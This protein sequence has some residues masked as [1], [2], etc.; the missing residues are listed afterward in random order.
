[1]YNIFWCEMKNTFFIFS[2]LLLCLFVT[3]TG[4]S[5]V[6]LDEIDSTLTLCL[7]SAQNQSTHGMLDCIRRAEIQYDKELNYYY[8]KLMGILNKEEQ[9]KLKKAQI[10]WLKFRDAEYEFSNLIYTN[11]QG[12][13][14]LLFAATER[15]EVVKRRVFHLKS[16]F[17]TISAE[18]P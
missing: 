18:K 11:L 5:Q 13:M 12:T 14:W 4:Y 16:Y 2:L 9:E 3:Q 6:P 8:K 1:M 7:D 15:T 10:Q 17:E